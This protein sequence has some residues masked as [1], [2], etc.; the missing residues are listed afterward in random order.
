MPKT[1]EQCLNNVEAMLQTILEKCGFG[2]LMDK[3]DE[4]LTA[5]QIVENN[6]R[7]YMYHKM[8]QQR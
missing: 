1:N 5:T 2:Q 3:E 7:E 4:P 6:K 8:A